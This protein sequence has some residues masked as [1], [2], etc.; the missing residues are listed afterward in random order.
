MTPGIKGA[1]S[2][3]HAKGRPSRSEQSL[4][5]IAK[6]TREVE[7][8]TE[9]KAAVWTSIIYYF[10]I[11]IWR[12]SVV[13][14][15]SIPVCLMLG[16][17]S[18]LWHL[19]EPESFWDWAQEVLSWP[20]GW[21]IV[22][23]PERVNRGE[24]QVCRR[25]II[26]ERALPIKRRTRFGPHGRRASLNLDSLFLWPWA[27]SLGLPVAIKQKKTSTALWIAPQSS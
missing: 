2:H 15:C 16:H 20:T 10:Y 23:V 12:P 19:P 24:E 18:Y 13:H 3:H 21:M 4:R 25:K 27:S 14:S 11:F 6:G 8:D 7:D 17:F 1:R 5:W 9:T 26:Q 22:P